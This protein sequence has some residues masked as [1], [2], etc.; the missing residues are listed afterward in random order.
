MY[1]CNMKRER[2][3]YKTPEYETFCN[4]LDDIIVKKI[5]YLETILRRSTVVS[6]KVAK[7]LVNTDL[8]ELRILLN[9]QY[10]VLFFTVDSEDLNQATELLFLCGFIKK[11]TKDY[12][13]HVNKAT[14]ILEQ[15]TDEK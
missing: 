11:S 15:W 4:S 12:K 8:Y 3:I 10:R 9:N 14:K 1:I 5:N 7:K 2:I 13:K 6:G